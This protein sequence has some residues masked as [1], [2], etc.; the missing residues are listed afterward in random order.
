MDSY[1]TKKLGEVCDFRVVKNTTFLPYIGMEDV[2]SNTGEFIG[3]REAR[4]VKSST[5]Y[6]DETCV[7]YGKLRPYLNKVFVPDFEGHSSTEFVPLR[8]D[9][10]FLTREWLAMWLMS[11]SILRGISE[12]V[13]GAR[14]PRANLDYLRNLEIPLPSLTEQKK[15]VAR[16]EKLLAKIKEAR[17]LRAEARA[18]TR[19]LLSAE[20]HKILDKGKK[21]GWEE[22]ELENL[23]DTITPPKKIQKKNFRKEGK[24]PI[25]DQSQN[26]IAGWTDDVN[27]L[28]DSK[29]PVVIFGDHTCAVKYFEGP[30]AQ[31]ADGIK[32]LSA[33]E[34]VLTKF[35]YIVLK[36]LPIETDGY[37]RHF[38][39]LKKYKILL[40]PLTEQK[41]IVARLDK[42]SV[43]LKKLE[44]YQK[45]TD[46]DLVRLEQS[47]LH[48]AFTKGL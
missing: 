42:L 45:S 10:K 21:K 28:I 5:A 23:I 9:K 33:K 48:Q 30:F 2:E 17:Q 18:A 20:L 31:G 32:V 40:P 46:L 12:N 29:A 6:F 39:L 34:Q 4:R 8:P 24:Y 44:E 13:A 16:M 1:P 47:I 27:S 3:S 41:K 15:I 7:L 25:I 37:R 11:P 36:N 14:M 19:V 22:K 38:S 26:E 35:L 43:K